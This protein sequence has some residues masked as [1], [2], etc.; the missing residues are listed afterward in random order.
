MEVDCLLVH[1]SDAQIRNQADEE[2]TGITGAEKG[3]YTAAQ[4]KILVFCSFPKDYECEPR[5]LQA[6]QRLGYPPERPFT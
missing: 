5:P 2:L 1:R 4:T 3:I 6:T